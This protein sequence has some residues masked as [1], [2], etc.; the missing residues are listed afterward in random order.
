M[1]NQC[2][3]IEKVKRLELMKEKILKSLYQ[4][5]YVS[6][7]ELAR[8]LKVSKVAVWKHIQAL[9]SDGYSIDSKP[10]KGYRLMAAPD[11]LLPYEIKRE[12]KTKIVGREIFHHK[13]VGSTQE[14]AKGLATKGSRE[15]ALVVAETQTA[16]KGRRNRSWCSPEG[17]IYLSIILRP[18]MAPSQAPLMALLAGV[19]TAKTIRKLY[20]LKAEL[21]WPNDIQ[22]NDRKVGGVLIEIAAETDIIN[23]VVVGIG[24]NA[25]T[26]VASLPSEFR[27]TAVSL[28]EECGR[29]ISRVELVRKL[30][31]EIE[32]LYLVFKEQ[33]SVPILEGW[34]SMTNTL[35]VPVRVT[36]GK[37][38]E[39]EAMDVDRDGALI[40]K[41]ADG[42]V[43]RVVAGDVS[44][45]RKR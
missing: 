32:R 18:E 23:W 26:K 5:R 30:L 44:L 42:G 27:A 16:G 35:G 7:T 9:K 2:D 22:I 38:I 12:L 43:R 1:G 39:G 4:G 6:G 11:L 19:A 20:K 34:R 14:I 29:K 31:E 21:K 33:G 24:L 3:K 40:I 45:C 10:K 28:E 15:G 25:N 17:G 37:V 41:L 8:R 36:N 13:E